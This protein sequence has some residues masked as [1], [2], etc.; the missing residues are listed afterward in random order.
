MDTDN[1]N[2]PFLIG[3]YL[4]DEYFCDRQKE[5]DFLIKQL[6]NGRNVALISPRRMGKMGLIQHCFAQKEL[7]E[8]Y[9]T[10][11]V[12]I[13]ST[14]S[15]EEFIQEFGKVVYERTK[16][17]KSKWAEKFF[18]IIASLRLG[19]KLDAI[20]GEPRFDISIGEITTPSTSLDEIFAYLEMAD[21]PCIVAID[22]F[23]QI[24]S[25]PQN[26]LEALLR[27]KIQ[28][29]SNVQFIFS[30]SKRHLMAQMFSSPAKPFYQSA[31]T[32]GLDPINLDEYSDFACR[33]FRSRGKTIEKDAVEAVYNMFNGCTW[34]VQLLLNELF[35]ETLSGGVCTKGMLPEACDNVILVQSEGYKSLLCKLTARQRAVLSAIAKEK[36][37]TNVT[38][39]AFVGKYALQSASAVQAALKALLK[40]DIITKEDDSYRVYDYLLAEW[41]RRY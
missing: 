31:I 16:S 11:F 40:D 6:T 5:T 32:M 27:T 14:S 21:K 17:K 20:S 18:Q 24:L 34:F 38:S 35:A 41:I 26:K 3:K 15:L 7:S 29:C 22:E 2:N 8:H 30:G 23:Q 37:A 36:T 1:A 9:Y 28:Q 39:S 19:F 10:F 12:D 25:Y 33:L 4:S 13:Y